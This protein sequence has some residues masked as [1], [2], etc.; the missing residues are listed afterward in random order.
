MF[1]PLHRFAVEGFLNG[2]VTHR[3][4]RRGPVPVF[5]T[6]RKPDHVAGVDFLNRT[7]PAL[8]PTTTGGDNQ[9]LPQRVGVPRCASARLESDAGTAHAA[10]FGGVKQGINPYRTGKPVGGPLAEGC[11]PILLISIF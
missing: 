10:R 4:G 7:V 6:G 1:Q 5:F 3:R 11:E 9:G 8:H 2:N